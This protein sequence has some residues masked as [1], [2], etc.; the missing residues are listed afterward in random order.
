MLKTLTVAVCDCCGHI[1]NARPV[2]YRNETEYMI[3]EGWTNAKGN[4]DM[5]LCPDCTRRLGLD[6][7][8]PVGV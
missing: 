2:T 3:P 4:K 6:T 7:R 8:K 5:I 1:D